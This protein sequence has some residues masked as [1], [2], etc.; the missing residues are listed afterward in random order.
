MIKGLLD[1]AACILPQ[2]AS[3]KT[4]ES[5][6]AISTKANGNGSPGGGIGFNRNVVRLAGVSGALA[7]GLGAYGAHVVMTNP[8]VPDEQKISFRTANLYH[9]IGTGGLIAAS[10]G[11]FPRTVIYH[12]D[13]TQL[14]FSL[15]IF[16]TINNLLCFA[17]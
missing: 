15:I 16:K 7:V 1:A 4:K 3:S 2:G 6:K 17:F 9:F 11:R 10:L 12:R 14:N 5:K 8:D 13:F